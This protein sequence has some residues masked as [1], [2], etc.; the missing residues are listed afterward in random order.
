[1]LSVLYFWLGLGNGFGLVTAGLGLEAKNYGLSLGLV[2]AL[3]SRTY[4]L[5]D[6][7]QYSSTV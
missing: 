1:M 4:G 2:D 5:V 7:L 6:S 3:A